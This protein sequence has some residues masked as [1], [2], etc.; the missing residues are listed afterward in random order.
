MLHD[1]VSNIAFAIEHCT[2]ND[3][4]MTHIQF[5]WELLWTEQ[6]G[7]EDTYQQ[8]PISWRLETIYYLN[9]LVLFW[10]CM[11][12]ILCKPS[13]A[14]W[15]SFYL[16]L[17]PLNGPNLLI[18]TVST[19]RWTYRWGSLL[20]RFVLFPAMALYTLKYVTLHLGD[21]KETLGEKTFV[22]PEWGF[23]QD[24]T[25]HPPKRRKSRQDC[26]KT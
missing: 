15:Y 1:I 5:I 10:G 2:W 17:R 9:W 6:Q 18:S 14:L 12:I 13:Y 3:A 24:L 26:G 19:R 25:C 8:L 11:A 16:L 20:A 23:H 22:H 21:I 7:T 4:A